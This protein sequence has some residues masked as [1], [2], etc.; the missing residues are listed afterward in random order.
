MDLYHF[1]TELLGWFGFIGFVLVLQLKDT[2]QIISYQAVPNL[3][4][5]V[6]LFMKGAIGGAILSALIFVRNIIG[7]RIREEHLDKFVLLCISV[8]TLTA[9]LLSSG[10][11]TICIS[12]AST[13]STLSILYRD[14]PSL[15]RLM[16]ILCSVLWFVYAVIIGSYPMMLIESCIVVSGI[17]GGIRHDNYFCLNRS[18]KTKFALENS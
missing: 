3:F 7:P 11:N 16:L 4:L 8:L 2:R 10:F 1:I 5:G 15:S 13:V 6:H 17:I 9:I 14:K 18:M 12:L